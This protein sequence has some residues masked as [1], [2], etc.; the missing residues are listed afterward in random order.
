MSADTFPYD[1]LLSHSAK[2]TAGVRW[3]SGCGPVAP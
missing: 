2:D 1:V 3:R